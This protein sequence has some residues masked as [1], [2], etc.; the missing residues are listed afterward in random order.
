MRMT[1]PE[2]SLQVEGGSL[3]WRYALPRRRGAA[4]LLDKMP[5][6][7]HS[8][9]SPKSRGTLDLRHEF[10]PRLQ[11]SLVDCACRM[12]GGLRGAELAMAAGRG[13]IADA[14]RR[15]PDGA[16]ICALSRHRRGEPARKL[17][18]GGIGDAR[19]RRRCAGVEAL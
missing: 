14:L 4:A 6:H 2:I 7:S 18:G 19:L 12:R 5:W 8:L 1:K 13:C 17:C 16:R 11:G 15:I 9:P 3:S 10:R